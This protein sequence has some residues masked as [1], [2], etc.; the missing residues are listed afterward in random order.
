MTEDA[1]GLPLVE[2][3]QKHD[4]MVMYTAPEVASAFASLGLSLGDILL[5]SLQVSESKSFRVLCTAYSDLNDHLGEKEVVIDDSVVVE[6]SDKNCSISW[7]QCIC[8]ILERYPYRQCSSVEITGPLSDHYKAL[9]G[10]QFMGFPVCVGSRLRVTRRDHA[11]YSVQV[12]ATN[13]GIGVI[14]DDTAII[15]VKTQAPKSDAATTESESNRVYSRIGAVKHLIDRV[16]S[17]NQSCWSVHSHFR[18]HE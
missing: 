8:T 14:L 9:R 7:T 4:F 6:S 15:K 3:C 13:P 11:D 5:V 17:I 1:N 12:Q 18:L 2:E 10:S 16:I